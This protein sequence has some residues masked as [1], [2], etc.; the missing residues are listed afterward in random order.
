[1]SEK[2]GSTVPVIRMDNEGRKTELL[3]IVGSFRATAELCSWNLTIQFLIIRIIL[4]QTADIRIACGLRN[5]PALRFLKLIVRGGVVMKRLA[6]FVAI[7]SGLAVAGFGTNAVRAQSSDEEIRQEGGHVHGVV[8]LNAAVE[9]SR[10]YVEMVSPAVNIVG[11]EHAPNTAEQE[12]AID[13]AIEVLEAGDSLFG[14]PTAAS[15]SLASAVVESDIEASHEGEHDHEH[16]DEHAE[17]EDEHDHD[18][19]HGDEHAEHEGEHDH[20]HEHGDEHAE[21][22]HSEFSASYEFECGNPE[23]LN[24]VEVALFDAFPGIEQIEVQALTDSG[25]VGA[26]LTPAD[27]TLTW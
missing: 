19:D 22:V 21:D 16:G 17:H 20:D 10:F 24:Q 11:F 14:L 4:V 6:G 18:H 7:V 27:A 2:S 23:A 3:A 13:D 5:N 25:Q 8:E 26:D 9:G 12:A 15:C 1:M